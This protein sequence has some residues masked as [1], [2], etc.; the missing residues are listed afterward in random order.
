MG[1]CGWALWAASSANPPT[2]A[3][4]APEAGLPEERMWDADPVEVTLPIWRGRPRGASARF[5]G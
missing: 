2:S 5:L 4:R 3:L 1:S